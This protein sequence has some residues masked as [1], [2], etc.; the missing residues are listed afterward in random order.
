V[1]D[2]DLSVVHAAAPGQTEPGIDG[3]VSA[4]CPSAGWQHPAYVTELAEW[5]TCPSCLAALSPVVPPK[6]VLR[7]VGPGEEGTHFARAGRDHRCGSGACYR[8][9]R[10]ESSITVLCTAGHLVDK[11]FTRSGA[12]VNRK[13]LPP[14]LTGLSVWAPYVLDEVAR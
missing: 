6:L 3:G 11:Y 7:R 13:P 12:R 9:S 2:L 8:V 10:D 5:V 4:C 14:D 1:T